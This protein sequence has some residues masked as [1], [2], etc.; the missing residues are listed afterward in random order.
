MGASVRT[1]GCARVLL[2]VVRCSL[3]AVVTAGAGG[4]CRP[5]GEASPDASR[6]RGAAG[7][8][9]VPDENGRVRDATTG[10]TGIRGRWFASADTEDCQKRGKHAVN[11]CSRFITPDPGSTSFGPTGDLGMCTVGV[12]AKVVLGSDGRMDSSNIYGAWIGLAFTDNGAYDAPAHGVTG[13][14]FHLDSEPPLGARIRVELAGTTTSQAPPLWGGAAFDKSPVHA[15]HN[16]FRWADIGGPLWVEHPP[17]F[18]PTELLSIAFHVPASPAGAA[19]FS[20]CIGDLT[21]LMN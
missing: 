10:T 17:R 2:A 11:E 5:S 4:G 14:A 21:A 16:E 6:N 1:S 20:F 3:L 13:F 19:T 7:Q 15:G 8:A 9:L 18:D 12:A